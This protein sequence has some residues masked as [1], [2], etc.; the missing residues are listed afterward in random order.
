MDASQGYWRWERG[1]PFV[2]QFTFVDDGGNSFSIEHNG[3]MAVR[4]EA[5]TSF[6]RW[7]ALAADIVANLLMI[8]AVVLG[9]SWFI[10]AI[11]DARTAAL[12]HEGRRS[13][14]PQAALATILALL[15]VLP[16]VWLFVKFGGEYLQAGFESGNWRPHGPRFFYTAFGAPAL[17]IL[18]GM[19][20]IVAAKRRLLCRPRCASMFLLSVAVC[21]IVPALDYAIPHPACQIREIFLSLWYNMPM[22]EP[23]LAES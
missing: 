12:T 10:A 23:K 4:S 6:T 19:L 1:W 8:A 14:W 17:L 21:L 5:K 15:F 16:G 18:S 20:A 11:P 9:V 22:L 13:S 2:Y 3:S 7:P